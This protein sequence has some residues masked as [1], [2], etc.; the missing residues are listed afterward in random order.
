MPPVAFIRRRRTLAMLARTAITAE[1]RAIY[2]TRVQLARL[3]FRRAAVA[4]TKRACVAS[5]AAA[6]YPYGLNYAG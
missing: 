6:G 3:A 4:A 5:N 1:S 2:E